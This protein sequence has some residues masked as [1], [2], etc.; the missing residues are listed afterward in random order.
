MSSAFSSLGVRALSGAFFVL[1][2]LGS[3]LWSY[4]SFTIFFLLVA[5]CSLFEFYRIS[6]VSPTSRPQRFA[7][8]MAA[9]VLYLLFVDTGGVLPLPRDN[10]YSL[11]C[12]LPVIVFG[13]AIFDKSPEPLHAA[14]YT[15]AGLV[16]CVLPFGLLH[17]LAE[18]SH[19]TG[20]WRPYAVV[21]VFVLIW[22]NDTFAYLCGR[23]FGRHKMIPSI[24][25]GKSWEGTIGGLVI[26]FMLCFFIRDQIS[27]DHG[28]RWLILGA[29]VPVIAT[30]GD[31]FESMLKRKAGVKD[32]GTIMPGHGGFLDR[33]D[34]LLFVSPFVVVVFRLLELN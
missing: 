30:L 24:S 17:L 1:L 34:S 31:L 18:S 23:L 26:T 27:A 28:D 19:D 13:A 2:L 32:S 6:A 20:N 10:S 12:V 8:Y 22:I 11:L 3:V 5:L 7:G 15:M 25:P 14:L 4:L 16:Y 29:T 21:G 33:F 9:L